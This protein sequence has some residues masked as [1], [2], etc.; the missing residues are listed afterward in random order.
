[1]ECVTFY[2][3]VRRHD[4]TRRDKGDKSSENLE[5]GLKGE[6]EGLSED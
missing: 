4:V 3:R 5:G 6:V 2:N 1:M